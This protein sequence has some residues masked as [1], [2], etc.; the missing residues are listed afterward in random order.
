MG[1]EG[2]TVMELQESIEQPPRMIVILLCVCIV[3]VVGVIDYLTG[4]EVIFSVFYLSAVALAT[5]RL[6]KG[7]GIGIACLSVAVW[8]G[9]DVAAGAHYRSSFVPIWNACILLT[10]YG[11]VCWLLD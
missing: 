9:G 8:I 5:W 3:A 1:L 2:G 6:G 11:V 10:F 7:F 4:F